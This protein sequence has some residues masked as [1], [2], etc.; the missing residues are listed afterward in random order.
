MLSEDNDAPTKEVTP[1]AE[2]GEA[3]SQGAGSNGDSTRNGE[4]TPD[5]GA[6]QAEKAATED[7]AQA[8]LA[9]RRARTRKELREWVVALAVALIA[10]FLI[11]SFLFTVIRVDGNSMKETLHDGERMIVTVLDVKLSGAQR[12]DVVICHFPGRTGM[13]GLKEDF[14]KRVVGVGGDVIIMMNGE[15][16]VNGQKV[17]EPF[18]TYPSPTINGAWE[19]PEGYLFVCGDNRAGSHDS[20][21]SDVGFIPANDI[22]GKV[23]L[24]MWPLGS[25]RVVK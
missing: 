14:V 17:D 2:K 5:V 13:F 6:A 4:K 23:R 3:L 20:R 11:R 8:R 25:A 18:V 7:D 12:G 9:A 16:F 1:E 19:V 10:V 15:T 24:V 22:V 21:S